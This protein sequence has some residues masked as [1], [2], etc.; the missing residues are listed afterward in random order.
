MYF[1]KKGFIQPVK[2]TNEAVG[3]IKLK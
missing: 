1:D 2:I 3:K